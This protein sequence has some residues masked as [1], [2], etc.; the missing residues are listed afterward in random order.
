VSAGQNEV[1]RNRPR[2]HHAIAG[3]ISPAY[4]TALRLKELE[5]LEKMLERIDN[6]S[7]F[8][9]LDRVLNGF[10]MINV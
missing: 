2:K 3:L 4:E 6:M 5:T 10:V 1:K 8:G 7:V 9:G